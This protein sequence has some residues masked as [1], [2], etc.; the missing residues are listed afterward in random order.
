MADTIRLEGVASVQAMIA[1]L[2]PGLD[3]AN[4]NAQNKMAYELMKAEKDQLKSALDR[5]TPF[6]VNSIA[7]KKADATSFTVKAGGKTA[8]VATGDVKGAGVFVADIAN[9]ERADDQDYLGVQTMGGTTAG[10]RPSE[11]E[12]KR[13]GMMPAGMVWVHAG[14]ATLNAYGNV[15]GPTIRSMLADLRNNGRRGKKFF[16]MGSPGQEKG[17]YINVGGNWLPFIY[18]VTP[19]VYGKKLGFYERAEAEITA[20]FNRILAEAVDYQLERMAR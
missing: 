1:D 20:N 19:R 13:L 10:P 8:T 7:Y 11:I 5:P 17:V 12:L 4:K 9:Q 6:S 14:G 16:I 18:F 15:P 3:R 2:G